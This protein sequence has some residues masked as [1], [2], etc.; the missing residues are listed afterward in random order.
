MGSLLAGGAVTVLVNGVFESG[1][2]GSALGAIT[3][4]AQTPAAGQA[5]ITAGGWPPEAEQ[6]DAAPMAA[7][8][9]RCEP[10]LLPSDT[11]VAAPV[12]W[13][14]WEK[15]KFFV[16][17][18]GT[19]G[20]MVPKD[21]DRLVF[22]GCECGLPSV[23]ALSFHTEANT[24]SVRVWAVSW[25]DIDWSAARNPSGAAFV[26]AGKGTLL[27]ETSGGVVA[28]PDGC[29]GVAFQGTE[30]HVVGNVF[31]EVL[32]YI[33]PTPST[34]DVVVPPSLAL[35]P[36]AAPPGGTARFTADEVV[37]IVTRRLV[38][39]L[40]CQDPYPY[41]VWLTE[42]H[43]PANEGD[44]SWTVAAGC[45]AEPTAGVGHYE[46]PPRFSPY[47]WTVGEGVGLVIPDTS[48]AASMMGPS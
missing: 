6:Q 44:G 11:K 48:E 35:P 16:R 39:Q 9:A 19:D 14:E 4:L 29:T 20:P 33:P 27:G 37:R 12:G 18:Y 38:R 8:W 45:G 40:A 46:I 47:Q 22:F 24:W 17:L 3:P 26:H 32:T 7:A 34:S 1:N 10:V 42:Y 15:V 23:S 25:D 2:Q 36:A 28:L 5:A 13:A 21:V 41:L 43:P 30:E 31:G